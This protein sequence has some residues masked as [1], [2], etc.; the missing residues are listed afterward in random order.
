MRYEF[1]KP[2]EYRAIREKAPIAYLPWGSH[3]WHGVQNPLG[4]DSLKAHGLCLA[5]CAETGGIVFPP[6]Y[7][8]HQSMKRH[9]FDATLEFSSECVRI[10]A[11]EY[12]EQ[13]ADE[14]FKVIVLLM[15]HYGA[16][17]RETL[18]ET[19]AAFNERQQA[20][21]AWTFPDC[22]AFAS[23]G[24]PGDHAGATETSFMLLFNP[25]VV[26][27]SRLPAEGELTWQTDGIGGQDPRVHASS[28]R[29]W[30]ATT[31]LVRNASAHIRELLEK[32]NG[33]Q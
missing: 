2:A 32:V 17:H 6:V 11:N 5:L 30:D 4:L 31:A 22:E 9:G 25:E 24:I 3:E 28:K 33:E 1:T 7:C 23:E 15:G 12:L 16:K 27:M 26:D 14:G 20:A 8:G 19:V 29:A 13:L 18:Q 10:L 21:I